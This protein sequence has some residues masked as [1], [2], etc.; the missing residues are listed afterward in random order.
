MVAGKDFAMRATGRSDSNP[1]LRL[2]N[3]AE[4]RQA[5]FTAATCLELTWLEPK[6]LEPKWLRS[7]TM[8]Y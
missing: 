1:H 8:L 4:G 2:N 5:G 3:G 7:Y 6:W